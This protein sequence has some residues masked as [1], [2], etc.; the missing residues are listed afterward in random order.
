[1][2]FQAGRGDLAAARAGPGSEQGR[3]Q[4]LWDG[5][6]WKN[7]EEQGRDSAGAMRQK[8]DL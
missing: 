8:N 3:D 4:P 7:G 6:C 1:M 2:Q 5:L